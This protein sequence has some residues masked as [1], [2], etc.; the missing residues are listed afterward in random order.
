MLLESFIALFPRCHSTVSFLMSSILSGWPSLFSRPQ[1]PSCY[2]KARFQVIVASSAAHLLLRLAH[3]C[4]LQ[5]FPLKGI[6]HSLV[7]FVIINHGLHTY[8]SFLFLNNPIRLVICLVTAR[9]EINEA[10]II[11]H[12][13]IP[14][15]KMFMCVCKSQF[16]LP[17]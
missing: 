4:S 6:A 11:F 12:E 15:F 5:L 17:L 16:E 7:V 14:H 13:K 3:I 10:C 2:Q 1:Y 9:S 8:H